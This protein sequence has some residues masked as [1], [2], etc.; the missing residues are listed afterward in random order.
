MYGYPLQQATNI[1]IDSVRQVLQQAA[2]RQQLILD[3]VI[4]C[5]FSAEDAEVY[6]QVLA[7]LTS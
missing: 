2:T 5:C 4:F 3:T 1:A 6:Q 7:S